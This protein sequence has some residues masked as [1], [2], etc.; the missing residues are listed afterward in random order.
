[1]ESDELTAQL[2]AARENYREL[3]LE[4]AKLA[5]QVVFW[6]SEARRRG[7]AGQRALLL[8]LADE[9][10]DSNDINQYWQGWLREKAAEL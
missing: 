6:R 9:I 3:V 10:G 1:M 2:K 7:T 5:E 8:Q 4:N